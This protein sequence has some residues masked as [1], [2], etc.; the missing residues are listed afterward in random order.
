LTACLWTGPAGPGA[1]GQVPRDRLGDDLANGVW[2]DRHAD[3][4]DRTELDLGYRL[5]VA[6]SP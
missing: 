5:I 4:L 6:E 2:Y 3:L 1:C